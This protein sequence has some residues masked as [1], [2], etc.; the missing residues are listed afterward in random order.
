MSK[1]QEQLKPYS[2]IML[3]ITLVGR[4]TGVL[5]ILYI[6]TLL[7][8]R[9]LPSWLKV[10]DQTP[11]VLLLIGISLAANVTAFRSSSHENNLPSLLAI[12]GMGIILGLLIVIIAFFYWVYGSG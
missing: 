6:F 3:Y 7:F 9:P 4:V 12:V 5:I 2:K 1:K 8:I 11:I 10:D